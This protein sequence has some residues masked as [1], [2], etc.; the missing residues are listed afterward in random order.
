MR[1]ATT[2]QVEIRLDESMEGLW[3]RV[4]FSQRG[5]AP[6][7]KD[8]D[9]C[10]LSEDGRTIRVMLTQE[11]TLSFDALGT[12]RVQVRFGSG[13]SACAT[14]IATIPILEILD[15]EVV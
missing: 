9:D 11:E 3:Y 5:K 15:E 2:P 8:Q 6:I 13:G 10:E 7:V 1:R 4:A 12:V 14:D